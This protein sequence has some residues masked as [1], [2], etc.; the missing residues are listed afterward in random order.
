MIHVAIY[1]YFVNTKYVNHD[2]IP[3]PIY[4]TMTQQLLY[5]NYFFDY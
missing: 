4:I 2:P 3:H 5:I 1:I